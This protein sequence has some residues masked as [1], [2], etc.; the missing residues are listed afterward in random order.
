M[1]VFP[2]TLR[3]DTPG[4][5][6]TGTDTGV[7]KTVVSCLIADQLRRAEMEAQ[8]R[9]RVG[10]LKPIGSGCERRREGLVCP[11]AEELAYAADFDPDIGD[12][13]TVCPIRFKA[14]LAPV[15]A[16]EHP[17]DRESRRAGRSPEPWAELFT[18]E[19][20]RSVRRLDEGC[21]HIVVE[22]IGGAMVPVGIAPGSSRNNP[23]FAT[24][25]DLM[26]AIG[27][28][29]IVVCRPDLGTL[30]HTALTCA[31]IR[32]AGLTLAGIVINGF[33]ADS[34]DLAIQTNP[35]W[36]ALQNR[37]SVLAALPAWRTGAGAEAEDPRKPGRWDVR[38]I[39]PA[40]REAMD[41]MDFAG[42]CRPGRTPR[43]VR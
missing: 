17:I 12:L 2:E 1:A 30:N 39:H 25:L 11:D 14:P 13:T 5:F 21:D 27:Y 42:L 32:S 15:A 3:P 35:R 20:E 37:T 22:G 7:G 31:A 33:D 26:A 8:P 6:V 18:E 10:V 19:L 9:S 40:L 29:V 38:R 41:T 43:R 23:T 4:V 28:P 34:T 24:V 16:M 36:L